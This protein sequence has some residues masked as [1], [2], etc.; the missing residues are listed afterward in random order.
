MSGY[1]E[2][3]HIYARLTEMIVRDL[4]R[5]RGLSR[6]QAEVQALD[7]TLKGAG[8]LI[9]GM[10]EIDAMI[11]RKRDASEGGAE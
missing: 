8:E 9:G 6:E 3:P 5:L 11:H 2:L 4:M 10:D 1:G 7:M